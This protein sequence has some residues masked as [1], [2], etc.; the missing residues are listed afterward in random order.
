MDPS[1]RRVSAA[2][3]AK[4]AAS[5]LD[6]D[7]TDSEVGFADA[8]EW[9]KSHWVTLVAVIM[10]IAQL[11]WKQR[12]LSGFYFRQDDIHFTELAL[13]SPLDW[14][15]LSYV[16]SGHLHPGVLLIVWVLARAALYSWGAAVLV[17]LVML[18][19]ASLAAWWLLRT[20]IGNRPAILI[21]LALYLVTPLTWPNDSWWQSGIE[22]LPLQA[23][24]FLSLGSHIRYIRTGRI[25]HLAAAAGWLVVGLVFFEKAAVIPILLFAVTAGFLVDGRLGTSIR[26]S[27]LRYWRA[28]AVYVVIVAVYAGVL[29]DTLQKSTVKAKAPALSDSLTFSGRL[30]KDTLLPGLLGGPW[31][32]Y[33]PPDGAVAWSSPPAALVWLA[34]VAVLA[35]IVISSLTRARTWRSWAILAVWVLLADIA[36]VLL[37]R[38]SSFYGLASSLALDTRYV[39]DAPAVAA[40]CVALAFWPVVRPTR[41]DQEQ[42]SRE[43]RREYFA[44]PGWRLAGTGFIAVLVIGSIVSVHNYQRA[45]RY[46]DA[47]G[48]LYWADATASLARTPPGSVI[49]DQV[50]PAYVMLGPTFY[51]QDSYESAVFGPYVSKVA[52]N[53]RWTQHPSGTIKHLLIFGSFGTVRQAV[54]QGAGSGTPPGG[55][56]CWP[57]RR[58]RIVVQLTSQPSPFAG[59]L[60]IGYLAGVAANGESVTVSYAGEQEQFTVLKGLNAVYLPVTVKGS[61]RSVTLTLA[62]TGVCVGDAEVGALH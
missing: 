12:F 9:L 30:I 31:K 45:T 39:A 2:H 62:G 51:G 42:L 61:S 6:A 5:Y 40:I 22:S 3:G 13:H 41:E 56:H 58:G 49:F 52:R 55:G 14:K 24:I 1:S 17:T 33:L 7:E 37:G 54:V 48:K 4:H 50:V 53:V 26:V 35:I 32:W 8:S 57:E 46:S 47:F 20:L 44:G 28:W 16:G 25:P 21:P 18:A 34:G 15:Y 43:G 11:V 29:L 36:P 60:R 23:A 19:I 27:L 59:L 10:I 38:V